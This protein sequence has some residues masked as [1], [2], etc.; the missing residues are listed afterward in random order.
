MCKVT[1]KV[2][3][4]TDSSDE[5]DDFLFVRSIA[6][7]SRRKG[8]RGVKKILDDDSDD[9]DEDNDSTHDGKAV[10]NP[11]RSRTG[12]VQQ[13]GA[14]TNDVIDLLSS[15]LDIDRQH[16]KESSEPLKVNG[17]EGGGNGF[18]TEPLACI[19]PSLDL[20]QATTE[21][22]DSLT[23]VANNRSASCTFRTPCFTQRSNFYL[24][25]LMLPTA[26]T[27]RQINPI[28]KS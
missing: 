14:K 13:Y 27:Y 23:S 12:R 17:G 15:P 16:G 11:V 4:D 25:G 1:C 20:S 19:D 3:E 10:T 6:R 18:G 8:Q 2:T 28:G 21:V 7:R 24:R 5:D 22:S 9:D 26:A